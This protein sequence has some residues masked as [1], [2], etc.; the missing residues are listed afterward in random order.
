MVTVSSFILL[1]IIHFLWVQHGRRI[2]SDIHTGTDG[3]SHI[4]HSYILCQITNVR[5]IVTALLCVCDVTEVPQL[6]GK[7]V[8][9]IPLF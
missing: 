9:C 5:S 3:L 4:M 8:F 2:Y 1:V 7:N 6:T